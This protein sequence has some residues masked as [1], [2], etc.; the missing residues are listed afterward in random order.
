MSLGLRKVSCFLFLLL[1][2]VQLLALRVRAQAFNLETRDLQILVATYPTE[3][4][5]AI[6]STDPKFDASKLRLATSASTWLRPYLSDD[7]R[8]LQIYAEYGDGKDTS[9]TVTLRSDTHTV[10]VKV[11]RVCLID[12]PSPKVLLSS[13]KSRI[14]ALFHDTLIAL[15]TRTGR[16]L[17]KRKLSPGLLPEETRYLSLSSNGKEI[18][19]LYSKRANL[20]RLA[21]ADLKLIQTLALPTHGNT[22]NSRFLIGERA[23]KV[24]FVRYKSA[25]YS[26][27]HTFYPSAVDVIALS[28]G[29]LVQSY[30][31][32][33]PSH[34]DFFLDLAGRNLATIDDALLHPERPELWVR[35]RCLG[36]SRNLLFESTATFI[37]PLWLDGN[38]LILG[39]KGAPFLTTDEGHR[40]Y[41][42]Y[43]LMTRFLFDSDSSL[44]ISNQQLFDDAPGGLSALGALPRAFHFLG[45]NGVAVTP[46]QIYQLDTLTPYPDRVLREPQN[47]AEGT[48][49]SMQI[50]GLS[51]DGQ[52]VILKSFYSS[53]NHSIPTLH[54][55]PARIAALPSEKVRA[56][57]HSS[58]QAS[59]TQ[60]SWRPLPPPDHYRVYLST[61]PADLAPLSPAPNTLLASPAENNLALATPL[62]PGRTYHWR[63]DA[64]YGERLV[65]GDVQYFS[66]SRARV[67]VHTYEVATVVGALRRDFDL[68]IMTSSEDTAWELHSDSPWLTVRSGSGLG[69][70][71]AALS[72]NAASLSVGDHTLN[73]RMITAEGAV[74]VPLKIIVS[75]L[76]LTELTP[77]VGAP[78]ILAF[79]P[80]VTSNTVEER[81]VVSIDTDAEV[82]RL[83]TAVP[84]PVLGASRSLTAISATTAEAPFYLSDA[85]LSALGEFD[86]ESLARPF[87]TAR[88]TGS[89]P[90]YN[91][92]PGD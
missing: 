71:S 65:R 22:V 31:L 68:P 35:Q 39:P 56:P 92:A 2:M 41:P 13:D 76:Q 26:T 18:H 42:N 55:L 77:I 34:S 45:S 29:R 5:V 60:L 27:N 90:A 4:S 80:V 17:F 52:D 15:D 28:S 72:I 36:T 14:F 75:P 64:V 8:S 9:G 73:L 53:R 85:S 51:S 19:V 46:N 43:R 10:T 49:E 82:I 1:C 67:T 11:Q 47:A 59:V 12:D 70:G 63:V 48:G 30:E 20:L 89:I 6:E 33:F 16:M 57:L 74:P 61:N 91:R 38:G 87:L 3:R 69:S 7:G 32:P 21:A 81:L 37:R 54:F 24:Y 86:L 23:G 79:G 84:L 88:R 58:V 50:L 40:Y 44:A 83:C 66:V 78:R 62:A 25:Q